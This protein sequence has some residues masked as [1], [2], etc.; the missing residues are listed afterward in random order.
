[1]TTY[2]VVVGFLGKPNGNGVIRECEEESPVDGCINPSRF[3]YNHVVRMAKVYYVGFK[4]CLY[5]LKCRYQVRPIKKIPSLGWKMK[6]GVSTGTYDA[7]VNTEPH[8]NILFRQKGKV[9]VV[10]NYQFD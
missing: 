2:H 6:I 9:E 3:V 4:G 7:F 8:F 5:Y 10:S 1:M